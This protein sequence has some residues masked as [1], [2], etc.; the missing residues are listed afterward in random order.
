MLQTQINHF[1]TCRVT[2]A[3]SI[4][5]GTCVG[6]VDPADVQEDRGP[7]GIYCECQDNERRICGWDLD[8]DACSVTNSPRLSEYKK[9]A[10]LQYAIQGDK[11]EI[12]LYVMYHYFL[13]LLCIFKCKYKV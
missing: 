3:E 5:R 8:V 11:L 2:G 6:A 9:A 10:T 1:S 13:N 12:V 7:Q 4:Y